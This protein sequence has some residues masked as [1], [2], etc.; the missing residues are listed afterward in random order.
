MRM[1]MEW[2]NERYLE[3]PASALKK[4]EWNEDMTTEVIERERARAFESRVLLSY[5][6]K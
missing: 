1:V 6:N 5:P 2:H 4:W 3:R